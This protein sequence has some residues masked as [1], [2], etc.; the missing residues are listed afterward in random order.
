MEKFNTLDQEKENTPEEG[1]KLNKISKEEIKENRIY[2]IQ[3]ENKIE[4]E[5]KKNDNE[6][7]LT[8]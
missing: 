1:K 7:L 5:I 4:Q 2:K 6:T 8:F 3:D